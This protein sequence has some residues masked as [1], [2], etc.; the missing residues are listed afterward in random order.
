MTDDMISWNKSGNR[1]IVWKTTD[2]TRDLLPNSFKY[3]DFSRFVR[4]LNTYPM[5]SEF[6]LLLRVTLVVELFS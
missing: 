5:C 6:G 2:F 3:N 4:H 1:F